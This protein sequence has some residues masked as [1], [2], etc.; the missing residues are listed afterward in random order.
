M[1]KLKSLVTFGKM[2]C[3]NS[4][5]QIKHPKKPLPSIP[6]HQPSI[7]QE[8]GQAAQPFGSNNSS[9]SSNSA[10]PSPPGNTTDSQQFHNNSIISYNNPNS[11]ANET[12]NYASNGYGTQQPNNFS[13]NDHHHQSINSHHNQQQQQNGEQ[14]TIKS[15]KKKGFAATWNK[16][17]GGS[18]ADKVNRQVSVVSNISES[19]AHSRG[20]GSGPALLN[21]SQSGGGRSNAPLPTPPINKGANGSGS[22]GQKVVIALYAYEGRDDGELSFEKNDKLVVVDDSEPDWWLAYRLMNP[23]R[24]GYIPMNFVVSN[25]IETEE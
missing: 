9:F 14:S 19:T 11:I 6:P 1:L 15:N 4:R 2:G 24:R 13:T 3:V 23:E 25:V 8:P 5:D 10:L 20:S 12:T 22:G 18:S 21:P 16:I 17:K 7:N